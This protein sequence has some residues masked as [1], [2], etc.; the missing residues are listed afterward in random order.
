MTL[1]PAG[2]TFHLPTGPASDHLAAIVENSDDAIL[3]KDPTGRIMSWNPAATRMYGYTPEEAIGQPISILIP[4]NRAGEEMEILRR[5]MG[6]D[7]VDHYETERLT[8]D[9]GLIMVSLTISPVRSPAGD[10]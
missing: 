6:G 9:G 4:P 8:K 3:S 1:D 2:P 10:V 7:R 5:I